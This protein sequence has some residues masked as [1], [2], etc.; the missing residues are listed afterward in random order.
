MNAFGLWLR[1]S[2]RSWVRCLRLVMVK[3]SRTRPWM[4]RAPTWV[5]PNSAFARDVDQAPGVVPGDDPHRDDAE[6][7]APLEQHA[8][9]GA[10]AVA[11]GVGDVVDRVVEV[12]EHLGQGEQPDQALEK[13]GER[14]PAAHAARD[15]DD[16]E[17][18]Q[19]DVG[20]P[21]A[22]DQQG[23]Q[24]ETVLRHEGMQLHRASLVGEDPRRFASSRQG[25]GRARG[26]IQWLIK[27]D[28]SGEGGGSESPAQSSRSRSSSVFNGRPGAGCR[29][30]GRGAP[31]AG[32]AR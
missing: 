19:A 16:P 6:G 26:E 27:V 24:P 20:Q 23:R 29:R 30:S 13:A 10:G 9:P 12:L 11:A 3:I 4:P 18:A 5:T 28:R 25:L 21:G 2:R 8:E 17:G 7:D 22:E 32:R 31:R 1:T 14:G 15:Q